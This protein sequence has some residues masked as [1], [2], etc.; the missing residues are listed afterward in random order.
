MT[1]RLLAPEE[2]PALA[3]GQPLVWRCPTDQEAGRA[4]LRRQ[5]RLLLSGLLSHYL[6]QPADRLGLVF[7]AGQQPRLATNWQGLPLYLSVS[8]CTTQAAVAICPGTPIGIDLAPITPMPDW[9]EVARL[10]LEP[11][12]ENRLAM[13]PAAARNRQFAQA[14]AVQEARL[15]S[16]GLPLQEWTTALQQRL[17]KGMDRVETITLANGELILALSCARS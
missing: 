17:D 6:G 16:L 11:A 5:A 8:Y 2:R 14:W 3:A 9:R 1:M 15:K 12:I 4:G 13:L 7:E 10:Y